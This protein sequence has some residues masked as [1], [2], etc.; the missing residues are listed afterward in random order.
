MSI[1]YYISDEQDKLDF[2]PEYE[3]LIKQAVETTLDFEEFNSQC[4][5]SVTVV[6]NERIRKLNKEY[7]NIDRET[8]VLSFPMEDEADEENEVVLGDIVL[9][10]EKAEQQAKEYGHSIE[11]EIAFLCVHSVLH[12]LGYDH[13][14]KEEEKDMFE[15]Q[16]KILEKMG[17]TRG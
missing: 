11:R 2:K 8:D 1:V 14:E 7:R 10:L 6:D 15:R 16:E 3:T 12:L 5:V 4:E 9:S 17:L 13:M